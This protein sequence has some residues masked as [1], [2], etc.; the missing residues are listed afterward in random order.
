LRQHCEGKGTDGDTRQIVDAPEGDESDGEDVAG[1]GVDGIEEEAAAAAA[2]PTPTPAAPAPA[3]AASP[4]TTGA[5]DEA[6][7]TT[8]A[9]VPQNL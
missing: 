9:V 3:A 8:A 1:L 4:P 2:A 5:T 6:A 7:T